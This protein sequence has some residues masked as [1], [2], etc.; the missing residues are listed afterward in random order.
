MRHRNRRR[1]S[2][3]V[4]LE[5]HAIMLTVGSGGDR[6]PPALCRTCIA[7]SIREQVWDCWK[8]IRMRDLDTSVADRL[9]ETYVSAGVSTDACPPGAT[10]S[11]S[12]VHADLCYK[13]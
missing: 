2:D 4:L 7:H 13:P 9:R 10:L 1:D 12:F 6:V 5:T 3:A 8:M 11:R